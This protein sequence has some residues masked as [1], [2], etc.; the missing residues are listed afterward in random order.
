MASENATNSPAPHV[1][2]APV[3]EYI[4]LFTK[5]LKKKQ[6]KWQDGRLK[7][8]T[9]NNKVMVYDERGYNVGYMHW[10]HDYDLADG[11]ELELESGGTIVQVCEC[12]GTQ[13]QD[14]SGLVDKRLQEKEQRAI[15]VAS[16]LQQSSS[17][18]GSR[19]VVRQPPSDHFQL[20]Q[21]P[22]NQLLGT[23]TG[24]HGRALAPSE[25]PF[26]QRHRA[27]N[28]ETPR[29]AK[30]P[31][32]EPSPP[33]KSGYAQNL[34]GTKL[35]LSSQPSSSF[36]QRTPRPTAPAASNA[37]RKPTQ[38]EQPTEK[39]EP[40]TRKEPKSHAVVDLVDDGSD[41]ETEGK[42][43]G[44]DV[45]VSETATSANMQPHQLRKAEKATKK[46]MAPVQ[47]SDIEATP[48]SRSLNQPVSKKPRLREPRPPSSP[49]IVELDSPPAAV[50]KPPKPSWRSPKAAMPKTRCPPSEPEPVPEPETHPPESLED[51][52]TEQSRQ[53][54]ALRI[55][56]R[57]KRGLMILSS[58]NA[59]AASAPQTREDRK[60][61]KETVINPQDTYAGSPGEPDRD[62]ATTKT[63]KQRGK[64]P[65]E[66]QARL[67]SLSPALTDGSR[68][69]SPVEQT[70]LDPSQNQTKQ[71]GKVRSQAD[72]GAVN[73]A[74]ETNSVSE[75]R[76]EPIQSAVKLP[77]EK[78]GRKARTRQK[79]LAEEDSDSNAVFESHSKGVQD[80]KSRDV[81]PDVAGLLFDD[82]SD[83]SNDWVP[84]PPT[85]Q[86]LAK[87]SK[88]KKKQ[89]TTKAIKASGR[90]REV[91]EPPTGQMRLEKLGRKSVKSREI[92]GWVFDQP[93][94]VSFG[95]RPALPPI[96]SQPSRSPSPNPL[97]DVVMENL[98]APPRSH[99]DIANDV[100]TSSE[101]AQLIETPSAISKAV[102]DQI[103]GK[104]TADT[105]PE[106]VP[107][108]T[109][110]TTALPGQ[111]TTLG[112]VA[113][114]VAPV[115]APKAITEAATKTT[116]DLAPVINTRP[117]IANPATR[118]RKAAV[119][120]DAQGKV[121]QHILPTDSN[122]L[123][124]KEVLQALATMMAASTNE[125]AA[126]L[127]SQMEPP[128]AQPERP[129]IKMKLPGFAPAGASVGDVSGPW[130]REAYDLLGMGRPSR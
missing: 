100:P 44:I 62:V 50:P 73:S 123:P 61:S 24:H 95:P 14:I 52:W 78:G 18:G 103:I 43:S 58:N 40:A 36:R 31:R 39:P 69:V 20:R 16:R 102:P 34:F 107:E 101:L 47:T 127:P 109:A 125:A 89:D 124:R 121:P 82:D 9:Y 81:H 13:E 116:P 113:K 110:K 94:A 8:H 10:R 41:D 84:P 3:L 38:V 93:P 45:E 90:V 11:E 57:K 64:K 114:N 130:T 122:L 80:P 108:V 55:K 66:Q 118:G 1:T 77:I 23:P 22:L 6:K 30:R 63:R 26:E 42:A 12:V 37:T 115:S 25:S 92:I 72:E 53:T 106:T 27:S 104:L 126:L 56:S 7:L 19:P 79:L 117:R 51:D 67:P 86:N 119:R 88:G 68:V 83:A 98:D 70:C 21:V 129:K 96:A 2:T 87:I 5:D 15:K 54:T 17:L 74:S 4:C 60:R 71:R 65:T 28:D 91:S 99:P 59:E 112:A 49:E 120:S 35:H 128:P 32:R 111:E 33:A 29:P 75:T 105:R 46:R 97:S 48:H 76:I 85:C